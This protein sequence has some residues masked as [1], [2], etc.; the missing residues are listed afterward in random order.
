MFTCDEISAQS[1]TPITL[2][3]LRKNFYESVENP[4]AA[5]HLNKTLCSE[6]KT[7]TTIPHYLLAAYYGATETL[8][9]KHSYNPIVKY[10]QLK[11]G[12]SLIE[13]AIVENPSSLETRFIRFSIL[14]Y[15]PSFLGYS[16]ERDEDQSRIVSLLAK[17]DYGTLPPALLKGIITFMIESKRL[18][19]DQSKTLHSIL[20]NEYPG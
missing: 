20:K 5:E 13:T 3:S 16:A 4:A 2:E 1:K 7:N 12:L 15:V 6:V 19:K 8:L 10:L 17:H 9:G 18:Q 11:S 14:H